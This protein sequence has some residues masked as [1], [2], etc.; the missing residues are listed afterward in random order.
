MIF[1]TFNRK[2]AISQISFLLDDNYRKEWFDNLSWRKWNL[3]NLRLFVTVVFLQIYLKNY[4]YIIPIITFSWENLN[5][6]AY[7]KVHYKGATFFEL[8]MKATWRP[9]QIIEM[10]TRLEA[11]E[12]SLPVRDTNF[13]NPSL[14]VALCHFESKNK[15]PMW[16]KTFFFSKATRLNSFSF[17]TWSQGSRETDGFSEVVTVRW[18]YSPVPRGWPGVYI[19]PEGPGPQ[20]PPMG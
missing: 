19:V 18:S 2:I 13:T 9:K 11:L 16:H 8:I 7:C 10:G 1:I 15:R 14:C 17:L 4:H 3:W 12:V 5:I 20:D 6:L